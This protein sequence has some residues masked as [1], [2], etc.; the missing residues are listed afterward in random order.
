[1]RDAKG[2]IL[3]EGDIVQ[4]IITDSLHSKG[5]E[6]VILGIGIEPSTKRKIAVMKSEKN[7]IMCAYQQELKFFVKKEVA[8][9]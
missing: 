3:N 2:N 6:W 8:V 4:Q 7:Y 9:C 5:A 1:M